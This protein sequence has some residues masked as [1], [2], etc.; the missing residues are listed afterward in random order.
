MTTFLKSDLQIF[1]VL[2]DFYFTLHVGPLGGRNLGQLITIMYV[3][4]KRL[5]AH[6]AR[7]QSSTLC[8]F[9]KKKKKKKKKKKQSSKF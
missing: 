6:H 2:Y 5:F 9:E 1:D 8:V 7:N 3:L 4:W